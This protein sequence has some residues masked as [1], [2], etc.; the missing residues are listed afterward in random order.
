MAKKKRRK[1][2]I[3]DAKKQIVEELYRAARKNFKRRRVLIKGLDDVWMSDLADMQNYKR[4][5]RGHKYILI[6]IDCFSKFL[7]TKPLKSKSADE[8][9]KAAEQILK[10]RRQKTEKS[11]NR[12][13]QGI[14]QCQI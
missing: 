11:A 9:A 6:V 10:E 3:T 5:N 13:G 7:W 4:E 12:S 14:F 2:K 1:I 8:V